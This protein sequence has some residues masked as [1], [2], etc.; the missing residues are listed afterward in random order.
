VQTQLDCSDIDQY[1]GKPLQPARMVEPLHNN[2]F[3][4]WVQAMHYPN[5]LH[6]DADYA[7]E[8]CWGRLT[9]P[10][11]FAIA[12]DDANG[13]APHV[14]GRIPNSHH[15]YVGDEWW[16]YGPRIFAGDRIRN[17]RIPFDYV[18]RE[19]RLA[20]PTCF[21]RGDNHYYNDR[22][23]KIATQRSTGI[24]YT[25]EAGGRTVA[26][27][28]ADA[29]NEPEWSDEELASLEER[30]FAWIRMLHDL[31]HGRRWWDDI[32]VGDPLPERVV[33]PHSL[34]SFT[35][36]C[37][38]YLMNIWGTMHR[39]VGLD[40]AALGFAMSGRVQDPVLEKQNPEL[41]DGAYVGPARGHLFPRW[42]RRIGMPR[43]YGYGASMGAWI[44][45]YFAGWAGECGMVVH[46]VVNYRGPALVGD[47][48]ITTGSVT[49][50][51]I[52]DQGRNLVQVESRMANQLDAT[53]ATAKAE[54]L[55]PTR[56]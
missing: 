27:A 28:K 55:L 18:I 49:D 31:G 3:R 11:S 22:Q 56:G 48:T 12:C 5:R 7:V 50:K 54:I 29:A 53:V 2:D 35:T 10:Q 36:E 51:L 41:T 44:L 21:Q 33:G 32:K 4:R 6:Y 25:A 45:D 15:L 14:V 40:P 52:D 37:R 39:R 8:G 24:R 13:C 23:E 17:E 26:N 1:L 38:A 43:A 42:A 20:G 47:I 30:K 16:F 9:A 19:T 34:V 46:S